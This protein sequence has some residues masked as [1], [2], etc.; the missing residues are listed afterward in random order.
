MTEEPSSPGARIKAA[1]IATNLT[2]HDLAKR[3]RVTY[4]WIANMENDQKKTTL[5]TLW[6]V[7]QA[8]GCRPSDLDPRLTRKRPEKKSEK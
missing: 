1:R 7:A 2:R 3:L 5:D 8:I 4:Q 6:E